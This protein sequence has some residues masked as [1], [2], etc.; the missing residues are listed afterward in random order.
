MSALE[1]S[2]AIESRHAIFVQR[3]AG[4]QAKRFEPF[5]LE[6]Q[7]TIK[8]RMRDEEQ[9]ITSQRRLNALLRDLRLLQKSIYNDY[10]KDLF[11][12]LELFS[13]SE[14]EFEL[15][16]LNSV[17]ET[18]SVDL[19]LPA[20]VQVWTAAN[21]NPLIFTD[22]NDVQLLEPFYRNWS[23][24]E[25]AR[26]TKIVRTGF[27]TGETNDAITRRITGKNGT[28]DK[29]TRATNK[30]MVRTATNHVSAIAREQTMRE[31]DDIV[32]GYTWVS[33]L[34]SRTSGTCR[35]RDGVEFRW[36]DKPLLRPP[37]H[38]NCRSSTVGLLD[39]RFTMDKSGT[40]RAS[41][42]DEGGAQISADTNYY[43]FLKNQNKAFQDEVL[44]P[45]RG[46]LFRSGGLTS[47]EFSRLSVDQLYRPL[48]LDEM[49]AK[50]PVAFEKAGLD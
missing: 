39:T 47:E 4:G 50:N 13:V 20:P 42:G 7:K 22:S 36:K 31:N 28:I 14:S 46:Q 32:L 18:V 15:G 30:A 41:K 8:G 11:S 17:L 45:T 40:T 23:Q 16:A 33:T 29:Q 44:G 3:F 2:I 27:A 35:S 26:V 5:L 21:A 25:I 37:A 12:Q 6:L 24:K 34:D 9:T 43:S 1:Q 49:K 19:T 48:N 38:I 10:N